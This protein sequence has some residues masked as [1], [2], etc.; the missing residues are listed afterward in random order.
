MYL[1]AISGLLLYTLLFER[2]LAV[3]TLGREQVRMR[4]EMDLMLLQIRRSEHLVIIRALIAAI[5]L[6]GLLGTVTGMMD[7]FSGIRGNQSM[8]GMGISQALITTQYGLLLA[9]PALI[10]ERFIS[11]R[12][13]QDSNHDRRILSECEHA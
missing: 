12:I 3:Y 7:S 8:V 5:P 6:L 13:E 4:S 9:T 2:F 1:I 11:Y 10:F